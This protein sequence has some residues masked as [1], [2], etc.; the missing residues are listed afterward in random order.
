MRRVATTPG[1]YRARTG[2]T[3]RPP[4]SPHSGRSNSTEGDSERSAP[5]N[6]ETSTPAQSRDSAAP[7]AEGPRAGRF[8]AP[9]EPDRAGAVPSRAS[10]VPAAHHPTAPR[11][12]RIETHRRRH[13]TTSRPRAWLLRRHA[14]RA[15]RTSAPGTPVC[16]VAALIA[17]ARPGFARCAGSL[18]VAQGVVGETAHGEGSGMS[19]VARAKR[20]RN[21]SPAPFAVVRASA[22]LWS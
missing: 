7:C 9:T 20:V 1:S 17:R 12:R 21:N 13:T 19:G 5:L 15:S 11:F 4:R 14:A 22:F 18:I 8:S 16:G 10:P 6:L 2:H 3:A